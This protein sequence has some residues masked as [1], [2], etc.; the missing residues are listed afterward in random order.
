MEAS[1]DRVKA[2]LMDEEG[3]TDVCV[4]VRDQQVLGKKDWK[5]SCTLT[6]SIENFWLLK[7]VKPR[8]RRLDL[9]SWRTFLVRYN[10]FVLVSWRFRWVWGEGR[11]FS[12]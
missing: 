3:E 10:V 9:E 11:R 2:I 8:T 12:V 5:G 7:R 1:N 4:R 6:P